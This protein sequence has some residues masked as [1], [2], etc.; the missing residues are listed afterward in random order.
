[1]VFVEYNEDTPFNVN[2]VAFRHGPESFS[3][4]GYDPNRP[5]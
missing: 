1:M 5:G 4:P 3:I 2:G